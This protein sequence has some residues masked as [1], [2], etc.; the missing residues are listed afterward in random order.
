ME[1][2]IFQDP[3]PQYLKRRSKTKS[4]VTVF[5]F[6]VR[7]DRS[8]PDIRMI[9]LSVCHKMVVPSHVAATFGVVV[10]EMRVCFQLKGRKQQQFVKE[11]I[12][13]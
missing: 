7:M 5:V 11:F 12:P 2:Q 3:K 9:D 10:A 4:G 6:T 1:A 8:A 13:M